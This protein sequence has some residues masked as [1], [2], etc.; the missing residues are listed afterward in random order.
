VSR[1]Q[2]SLGLFT[3][4]PQASHGSSIVLDVDSGLLLEL[5]DAVVDQDV[6]EVFSTQVS[7]AVGC[8]DFEDAVINGQQRHVKGSTAQIEDEHIPL[9]LV[10]LVES[11]RDGGCSGLVDDSLDVETRNGSCVLG[12]LSLGVVEVG[13]HCHD[14]VLHFLAEVGLSNFLHLDED[15]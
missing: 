12:C 10:L 9:V 4:G 2:N 5:S 14:S 7:V 11:I 1:G 13:R 8:L 15:H 6:V 3:L